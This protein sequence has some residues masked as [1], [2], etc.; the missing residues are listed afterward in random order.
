M[1]VAWP[2]GG[3]A[4]HSVVTC[5]GKTLCGKM[6]RAV[7][8]WRLMFGLLRKS[9]KGSYVAG[10]AFENGCNVWIAWEL[11]RVRRGTAKMQVRI[12]A[13]LISAALRA[14]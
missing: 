10:S 9:N 12:S 7:F 8:W 11:Q 14:N 3:D 1:R 4:T 13:R 5:R 6:L 2:S